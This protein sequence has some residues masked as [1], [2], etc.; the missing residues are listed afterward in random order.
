MALA[1]ALVCG[2]ALAAGSIASPA[3]AQRNQQAAPKANYSKKFIAAYQPVDAL[4]KAGNV[5]EA[6]AQAAAV[7][8]AVETPDDRNAAGGLIFNIGS[9]TDD[10]VMQRQG[11]DLMIASGR[12]EAAKVGQFN[13]TGYQLAS[14]ADDHEAARKYLE[15]AIAADYSFEGRMADGTARTFYADDMR[16]MMA[17]SYFE[18]GNFPAGLS[19][20]QNMITQRVEAGQQVQRDWITRGLAVAYQ[21]DLTPQAVEFSALFVHHYPSETSW[22]DAIAIQRNMIDYDA[23]ATL[24]LLRLAARTNAM[25]DTRTY[26]DYIEAADARRLPG[27]VKRLVD[28]GVAAGKLTTNDVYVAEVSQV[29]NGRISADRAELPALEREASAASSTAVTATA[30]GDAFLSY[31]EAA[32]AEAMYQIALGKS[33]VDTARVLTR[34]GIAQADQGKSAEAI[35]TFGKIQGDRAA[36]ARLWTLY[37][38]QKAAPTTVA[39]TG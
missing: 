2:S 15:A 6:K 22:A 21:N 35:E 38:R 32:K 37:A 34:L 16:A 23:H 33:G 27:E 1:V 17:E 14:Q 36:I 11:L 3:Q 4:V 25:R 19:Y 12:A 30:A 18:Q 9:E 29:A 20:L 28:Q 5:T 10:S 8:A 39:T 31:G 26:V 7:L 13:F 24:D